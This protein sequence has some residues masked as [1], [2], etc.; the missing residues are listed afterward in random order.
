MSTRL[1]RAEIERNRNLPS[2][3]QLVSFLAP[4]IR[5]SVS[6]LSMQNLSLSLS[7]PP[8]SFPFQLV[9]FPQMVGTNTFFSHLDVLTIQLGEHFTS[10]HVYQPCPSDV[11]VCYADASCVAHGPPLMNIVFIHTL[12]VL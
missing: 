2:S 3:T 9:R 11:L 7:I 6:R 8:P 12:S 5:P 1:N 10:G 4:R